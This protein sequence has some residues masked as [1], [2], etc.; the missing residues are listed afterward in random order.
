MASLVRAGR[1]VAVLAGTLALAGAG[2][3]VVVSA[4][5]AAT[6]FSVTN[7][8]DSGLG[9]LRQALLDASADVTGAHTIDVQAGL[10]PITLTSNELVYNN[11]AFEPL[12]IHGNGNTV[13][14]TA[15]GFRVVHAVNSGLLTIDRLTITG[16]HAGATGGGIDTDN[17]A[18]TITNSTISG[19][20]ATGGAGGIFSAGALTVINSTISGNT[21]TGGPGGG[22]EADGPVTLVY[23]TVVGNSAPSA[24]NVNLFNTGPTNNL[25]SFGSVVALPQGG[26]ANCFLNGTTTTSNGFNFSDDASCGFS[27]G[28]DKQNAGDPNLGPL[29]NNGGNTETR[30]PQPGSPLIDA[31]PTASCQADGAAGITTDQ[32]G[33]TR[34]QGP[35]CDIGA[36]EVQVITAA[37]P[38]AITAVFTG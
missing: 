19:N 28:T 11:A 32:R 18:V 24:S 29:A 23:A 16:A 4:P 6:T 22:L 17:A 3:M 13:I 38:G 25:T 26:G 10:G 2:F 12:T 34:P 35:G 15:A 7:S 27:A 9:S 21:T 31:I 36:V 37:A 30:L 33:V 20:T 5:A 8:N 1:R 14:Q